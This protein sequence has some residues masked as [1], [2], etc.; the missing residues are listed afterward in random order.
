MP[1]SRGGLGEPE[2]LPQAREVSARSNEAAGKKRIIMFSG[3]YP[4]R[5]AV[6]E[7]DAPSWSDLKPIGDFGGVVTMATPKPF[8]T[9]GRASRPL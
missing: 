9:C 3:L 4:I 6:R 8:M 2:L 5:M 7:D 1:P